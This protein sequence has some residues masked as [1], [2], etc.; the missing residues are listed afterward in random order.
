MFCDLET[1]AAKPIAH[2]VLTPSGRTDEVNQILPQLTTILQSL[3]TIRGLRKKG[4]TVNDMLSMSK[5]ESRQQ[6]DTPPLLSFQL[7][8][9]P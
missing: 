6:P 1:N 9:K 7:E 2:P 8:Q 5:P 4:E 3:I